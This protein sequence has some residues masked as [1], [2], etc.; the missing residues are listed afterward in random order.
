[1]GII[2]TNTGNQLGNTLSL[3]AQN[4]PTAVI[5]VVSS[6]YVQLDSSFTAGG[7][8]PLERERQSNL[9]TELDAG[10]QEA[11]PRLPAP[12]AIPS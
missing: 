9:N 8:L 5:N 3:T 2:A 4:S 1:M 10:A 6:T 11:T 7:S 12:D